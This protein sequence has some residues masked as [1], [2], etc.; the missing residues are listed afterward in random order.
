MEN[1][2]ILKEWKV[3]YEISVPSI[4]EKSFIVSFDILILIRFK[5]LI[6]FCLQIKPTYG[7][8]R[9]KRQVYIYFDHCILNAHLILSFHFIQIK[10]SS[11]G[12]A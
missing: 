11:V 6:V 7:A 2:L 9:V 12:I 3:N 5:P 4:R 1:G 10:M 8:P